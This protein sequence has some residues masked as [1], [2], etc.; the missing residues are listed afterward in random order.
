M[1]V[2]E[3]D[4]VLSEPACKVVEVEVLDFVTYVMGKD[5]ATMVAG[6]IHQKSHEEN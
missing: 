2:V 6:I 3:I 5:L 4:D 1:V